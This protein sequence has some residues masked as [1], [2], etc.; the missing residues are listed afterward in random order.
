MVRKD[1]LA[2][3]GE[4]SFE[5]V[6]GDEPVHSLDLV[7]ESKRVISDY[8]VFKNRDGRDV[9]VIDRR[10]RRSVETVVG[11][12]WTRTR[13]RK[14]A[15]K[16]E[17]SATIVYPGER[18]LAELTEEEVRDCLDRQRRYAVAFFVKEGVSPL[19]EREAMEASFKN[20]GLVK[21]K[22]TTRKWPLPMTILRGRKRKPNSSKPVD[23]TETKA[24]FRVDAG[25]AEVRG[26]ERRRGVV[27]VDTT[28]ADRVAHAASYNLP[29]DSRALADGGGRVKTQ[30]CGCVVE[31]GLRGTW[32][33]QRYCKGGSC[34][35]RGEINPDPIMPWD[36]KFIITRKATKGQVGDVFTR[37]RHRYRVGRAKSPK[38]EIINV[39]V[40]IS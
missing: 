37:G 40:K 6:V 29:R 36:P 24:R 3:Q 35:L 25:V 10:G 15:E 11:P 1:T 31:R 33:V 34:V 17:I 30:S 9:R 27:A 12:S 2:V 18:S 21:V 39:G 28:E 5:F 8:I 20:M 22:A 16:S 13:R 38:G 19:E 14:P 23:I 7:V 26:T 4:M 32:T